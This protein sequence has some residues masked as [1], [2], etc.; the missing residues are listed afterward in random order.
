MTSHLDA[1]RASYD[2]VAAAYAD[3]LADELAGKPVDRAMLGVLAALAGD[4][5]VGDLGCGPGRVSAYLHGLGVPD[6]VGVDLSPAMIAE[7]RR[8]YPGPRFEVGSIDRLDGIADGGLA[9]AVAWYSIIHTPREGVPGLL[10][11]CRRVVRPGGP[12]LLAFQSIHPGMPDRVRVERAYGH[13]GLTLDAYRWDPG[14][15][16]ALLVAAGFVAHT[17]A[18]REPQGRER[19]PQAYLIAV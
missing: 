7:A 16:M 8:R 17:T 10:A 12:L 14:T 11:E 9:G 4:G 2:T 6:V 5:P 15:V 13:E 18:V 3:Q 19:T 1:V